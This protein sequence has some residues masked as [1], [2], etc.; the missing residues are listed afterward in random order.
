LIRQARDRD[1]SLAGLPL[2]SFCA[3]VQRARQLAAKGMDR[4]AATMRARAD[5]YRASMSLPALTEDEWVQYV[6]Y[7]DGGDALAAYADHLD[8]GTSLPRVERVLADRLVVQRFWVALDVFDETHPLRRDAAAVRSGLHA[9]DAGDWARAASLLQGVPRRSPFAAWRLF[10]RAMVCF[11]A[12]DDDELRRILDRLPDDFALARTVA[13]W[14]RLVGR[15]AAGNGRPG[16]PK[17]PEDGN[18]RV[19]ALAGEL[20]RALHNGNVRAA[21][22]AIERLADALYP[23][24][25][26]RARIDLLEIAGLATLRDLLPGGAIERLSRR[27]LPAD[28]V[29]GVAARILLARQQVVPAAWNPCRP[30]RSQACCR[31][32][33]RGS[34]IGP[35]HGRACWRRWRARVG[36]PCIRTSCLPRWSRI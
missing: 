23:E 16:A 24:D 20:K 9:M 19:A 25:P 6:R 30:S 13:E 11:G 14:R 4:E 34:R 1:D 29:I 35:S 36:R 3:S 21:G 26:A 22:T 10:C 33:F 32:S 2:L 8:G 7:L 27:L 12:G 17:K 28:R 15:D 31:W 18:G 5:G